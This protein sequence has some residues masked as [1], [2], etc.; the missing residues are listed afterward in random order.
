[1]L[2]RRLEQVDRPQHVDRGVGGRVAERA[3]HVDL[4]REV[5]DRLGP[6]GRDHAAQLGRVA[7]VDHAQP[8]AALQ[9][10]VEVLAAA[11]REVVDDGDLV[12]AIEQ[13]VNEVR[14][15]EAGTAGDDRAHPA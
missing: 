7:D 10:T 15:D 11:G 9:G 14:P 13:G 12:T 6:L 2:A 8:R 3:A 1:V 4:R 5:E